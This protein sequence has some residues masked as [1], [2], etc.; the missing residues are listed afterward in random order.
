[1]DL[2][3][4]APPQYCLTNEDR[5]ALIAVDDRNK[6]VFRFSDLEVDA[7]QS[8]FEIIPELVCQI[9]PNPEPHIDLSQFS[10]I[11]VLGLM[12]NYTFGWS[13]DLGQATD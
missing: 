1:M 9:S 12:T 10:I 7:E 3:Q 11:E 13:V 2:I 8:I 6:M 5:V 4:N